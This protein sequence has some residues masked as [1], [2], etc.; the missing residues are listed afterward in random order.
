MLGKA[1]E[2]INGPIKTV[3]NPPDAVG[4]HNAD[5]A[6]TAGFKGGLILNEYHFT[7]ISEMLIER[8][9][10]G[11]LTHGELE[12]RYIAPLF[13]GDTFVPKARV[14]GEDPAGSG[15]LSL[16]VWCENQAGEKLAVGKASCRE[17]RDEDAHV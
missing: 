15:R 7:Q 6:R 11:W 1:G 14:L 9:G 16:E 3:R 13:G 12:M 8:F 5:L 10:L 2:V 17:I 4:M